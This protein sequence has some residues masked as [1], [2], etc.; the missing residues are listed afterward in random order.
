MPEYKDSPMMLERIYI[1][2]D[3]DGFTG[4]GDTY[5]ESG[6]YLCD[7]ATLTDL[8]QQLKFY[9]IEHSIKTIEIP[10]EAISD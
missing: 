6:I 9:A 7:S 2:I 3:G 5:E 8:L 10:T 1:E 4:Y